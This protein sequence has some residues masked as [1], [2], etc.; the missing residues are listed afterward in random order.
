VPWRWAEDL[1]LA[2]WV[3]NQRVRKKALDHGDPSEGMT[4][5]RA[6]R[7]EALGFDWAPPKGGVARI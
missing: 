5:A 3:S 6:A 1:G 7:L 4:A 2:T